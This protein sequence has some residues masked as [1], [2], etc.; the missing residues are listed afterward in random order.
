MGY[1]NRDYFRDGSY[2]AGGSSGFMDGAPTC[3]RILIATVVI[4]VL[5]MFW[6]RPAK[7]ADVQPMIDRIRAQQAELQESNGIQ[8]SHEWL[9]AIARVGGDP[10]DTRP[11]DEYEFDFTQEML[12]NGSPNV[13]IVEN[14]FSL[15]TDKVVS[16]GQ[17]WRLITCALCHD[18][19]G[20]WH[21]FI[22]MFLLF[23]FGQSVESTYGSK[24]FLIFYCV[25]A[26]VASFAFI[27]LELFTGQRHGAIGASGA[28]MAV[29][30]LFTMWN[31]GYTIRMYF[32][33]PIQIKYLLLFYVLFDI[34]PV[35]LALSGTPTYT[36]VGHAA[37]LGGLIFGFLYFRNGWQ[38]APYWNRVASFFG[39]KENTK[40]SRNTK[41]RKQKSNA[42][43]RAIPINSETSSSNPSTHS[44]NSKVPPP[45]TAA[46]LRFDAQLD[47]ILKKISD[48]GQD[49]LT[50]RERKVLTNASQRYRNRT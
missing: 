40:R 23:W 46:D 29:V 42:E 20:I 43:P 35:L 37:H 2:S 9:D 39:G 48:Q 25:A 49:S 41:T 31:P 19:F 36:G 22:N 28:V 26:L 30:C 27:G 32:L 16:S 3:K 24:E 14:W 21:I 38:L 18:R 47:E 34:H 6:T 12:L 15:D 4:F 44:P 1:D 17:V 33:F 5:Q 7:L 8:D 11:I 10:S 13:S 50:A 45:K